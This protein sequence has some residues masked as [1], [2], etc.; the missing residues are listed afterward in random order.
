MK[1]KK[2][3]L[4]LSI[5]LALAIACNLSSPAPSD[6]NV[7]SVGTSVALTLEASGQNPPPNAALPSPLPEVTSTPEITPNTAGQLSSLIP[8]GANTGV[9]VLLMTAST[10][11]LEFS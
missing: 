9:A 3:L 7:D 2:I 4:V 10:E 11:S 8:M 1:K 6:V 5:I